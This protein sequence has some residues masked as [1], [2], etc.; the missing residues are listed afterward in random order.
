[1]ASAFPLGLTLSSWL[2][3][4]NC[5]W[6]DEPLAPCWKLA[7]DRDREEHH[8]ER[9]WSWE[10][11]RV[12]QSSSVAQLCMFVFPLQLELI[13]SCLCSGWWG[14][15]HG[16]QICSEASVCL[17]L[18][19]AWHLR[20]GYLTWK[21]VYFIEFP[22]SIMFIKTAIKFPAYHMK[23]SLIMIVLLLWLCQHKADDLQRNKFK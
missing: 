11:Q 16:N 18:W 23:F 20:K 7:R 14:T 3:C 22:T 9:H 2:C 4:W 6:G 15:L 13:L 1:M 19:A 21:M 12:S 8:M 10:G 5:W 17:P